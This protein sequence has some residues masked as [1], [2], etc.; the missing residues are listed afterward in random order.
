M[1]EESNDIFVA[2]GDAL[3][4]L[5]KPMHKKNSTTFVRNHPLSTYVSYDRVFKPIPLYA[6]VNILDDSPL[7]PPPFLQLR[8]CLMGGLFLNEKTNKNIQI[9]YSL[10][11]KHSKKN[12]LRKSNR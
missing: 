7:R 1:M 2:G 12:S 11:Y 8:T 5:A 10:K 6:P 9:S 3:V 4:Y